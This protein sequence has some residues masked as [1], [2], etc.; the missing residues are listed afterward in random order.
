MT[1]LVREKTYRW[2]VYRSDKAP[3]YGR[4]LRKLGHV[5][6]RHQPEAL[7]KAWDAW[8]VEIDPSQVQSGFTVRKAA[9]SG[10]T[11]FSESKSPP[12]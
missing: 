4:T 6:A 12:S 2:I 10:R 9:G 5:S 7:R 11:V 3:V 1:H 8:P